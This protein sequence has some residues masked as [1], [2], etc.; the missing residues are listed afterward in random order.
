MTLNTPLSKELSKMKNFTNT[1]NTILNSYGDEEDGVPH[2]RKAHDQVETI[3][4]KTRGKP[5]ALVC[6]RHPYRGLATENTLQQKA[7]KRVA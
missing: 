1:A 2:L 7:A 5:R 4:K 3:F 6:P